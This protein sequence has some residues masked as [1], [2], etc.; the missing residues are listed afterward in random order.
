MPFCSNCGTKLYDGARF[1]TECG[2]SVA[3]VKANESELQA[4]QTPPQPPQGN[5]ERQQEYAGKLIKCPNCGEVL[6]SFITNCPS[7][8]YELRGNAATD[9]VMELY[10]ELNRTTTPEQ[11]DFMINEHG[12]VVECAYNNLE[13][14]LDNYSTT[15]DQKKKQEEMLNIFSEFL[16]DLR[17]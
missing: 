4:N 12:L 6:A 1:C 5:T 3:A 11:K 17:K 13:K 15:F 10:R 9:S 2:M 8:G 16:K 14:R 7:C